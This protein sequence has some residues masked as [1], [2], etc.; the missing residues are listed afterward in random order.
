MGTEPKELKGKRV[1]RYT[2]VDHL[3]SGG[4]A[5]I[6]LARHEAEG[7]FAKE[8]VLKILQDRYADHQEVVGMFLD[9]ARLGA[10][11]NHPNIVDV[12][13]VGSENGLRYIAMEHIPGKTLTEVVRRGIEVS[14]PL[15]LDHA[16]YLVAE[17][18]AGLAYMHDGTDSHRR[19]FRIVHRDISPSNLIVSYSGQTK[20][21]DFG[22][23]REGEGPDPESGAR[24]G[25]VSYMSP[26]QVQGGK[27]DGRSDIFSL[28]TILY[29]ITLGKRL[30]RGAKEVVMRRIVEENPPPPTYVDRSHPPALEL[31]VLR[32]LEKRPEKR[33][34]DA[35]QL[36]EELEAY[37][38]ASGA[39]TR[40]HQIAQY[41]HDMFGKDAQVSE[42][43]V[44]RA[45][46]FAD[47]EGDEDELD[48]DR[49]TRGAG[50][51]LADALRS[52]NPF[53]PTREERTERVSLDPVAIP[54]PA[55]RSVPGRPGD[56]GEAEATPPRPPSTSGR[57]ATPIAA[58]PLSLAPRRRLGLLVGLVLAS[59]VAVG[60]ILT[61]V[62]F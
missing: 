22:I 8:L 17:T 52:S 59:A 44:R 12:Y 28:G 27:L 13:D 23:A 40:N 55:H 41:L 33:Y 26:E 6:F 38:V 62:H 57:V 47:D 1:G 14:K 56:L 5:E 61:H 35:G 2:L 45:R 18:A 24:P 49:P 25:K 29:E 58:P 46:A 42:M 30:W 32:A 7:E 11:L 3:A 31:I 53:A 15:P 4:M 20:I 48:F 60:F 10:K 36:F 19:P 50:K 21:I 39:R 9:E 51:A 37:L 16:A 54:V 43:G 34:P